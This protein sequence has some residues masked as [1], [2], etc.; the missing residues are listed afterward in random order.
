MNNADG[1]AVV[2]MFIIAIGISL[3]TGFGLVLMGVCYLCGLTGWWL[4]VPFLAPLAAL[5]FKHFVL[6]WG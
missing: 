4:L 2:A 5:L 1:G 6:G 3:A